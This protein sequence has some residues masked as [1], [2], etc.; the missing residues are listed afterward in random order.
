MTQKI[1]VCGGGNGSHAMAGDLSLRGYKVTLF[2]H[3]KFRQ[4]IEKVLQ[5]MTIEVVGEIEGTANLEGVT[6]SP[7]EAVEDANTILLP[8]PTYAQEPFFDLMMPFFKEDQRVIMTTGNYGS[9][10]LGN[11]LNTRRNIQMVVGE[12]STLPYIA[13]MMGPGKVRV[14]KDQKKFFA[15]AFPAEHNQ[16]VIQELDSLYKNV[17]IPTRDSVETALNNLN[18]VAHPAGLLLN[19][20]KIESAEI[21]GEDYYLYREGISPSVARVIETVNA[22]R[23]KTA[24]ALGYSAKSL[25]EEDT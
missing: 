13:R 17:A 7:K 5:T 24:T 8:I 12:T 16:D 20:G 22:E 11:F 10:I 6:V 18:P 14:I 15:S 23:L 21:E 1:T 25:C 4:N 3:P 9:I 2:E 19:A